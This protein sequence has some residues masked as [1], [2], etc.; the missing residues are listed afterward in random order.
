MKM[1][2]IAAKRYSEFLQE[3]AGKKVLLLDADVAQA[4]SGLCE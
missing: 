1:E 2:H 3:N 4:I